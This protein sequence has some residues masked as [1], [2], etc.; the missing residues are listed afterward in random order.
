V[1]R[2]YVSQFMTVD[3]ST[4]YEVHE[5]GSYRS[6][7]PQ[8]HEHLGDG[9]VPVEREIDALE[10]HRLINQRTAWL[11]DHDKEEPSW[12]QRGPID[13]GPDEIQWHCKKKP[14]EREC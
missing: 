7:S 11:H 12:V 10:A 3:A 9:P 6:I 8:G 4:I 14:Y 2:Y 5:D 1:P 13:F